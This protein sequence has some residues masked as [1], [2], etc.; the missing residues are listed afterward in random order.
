MSTEM[1][2]GMLQLQVQTEGQQEAQGRKGGLDICE[3]R[4]TS[5]VQ[6]REWSCIT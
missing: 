6:N 1:G 2:R 3:T 5:F 4:G